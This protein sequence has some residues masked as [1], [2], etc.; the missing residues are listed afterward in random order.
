[1]SH[2]QSIPPNENQARNSTSS[3]RS[4]NSYGLSTIVESELLE[5]DISISEVE[6]EGSRPHSITA[7][8]ENS[9]QTDSNSDRQNSVSENASN[10][11]INYSRPLPQSQARNSI[12]SERS[13]DSFGLSIIPESEKSQDETNTH[14][15]SSH[16]IETPSENSTQ[17]D[18]NSDRQNSASE[19]TSTP[20]INSS[21]PSTSSKRSVSFY[22]PTFPPRESRRPPS[23]DETSAEEKH[24]R[25]ISEVDPFDQIHVPPFTPPVRPSSAY[26]R[27]KSLNSVPLHKSRRHLTREG[28]PRRPS[29][30][31]RAMSAVVPENPIPKEYRS[32][33]VSS[34]GFFTSSLAS[35]TTTLP[36]FQDDIQSQKEIIQEYLA[37]VESLQASKN[38]KPW[39]SNRFRLVYFFLII[40]LVYFILVGQPLWEGI[41][42]IVYRF[43][44]S[45]GVGSWGCALF[46]GWGAFQAFVPML[47]T[48]FEQEVDDVESRDSSQVALVIPAYKAAAVLPET[49]KAALKI[50]KPEQIFIIANGNSKEPTDNTADVC[51]EYGVNHAWVPVGSKLVAEFIGVA[52][53]SKYK[54]TML[55]DDDV[56]LPPNIPIVTDRLQGST[57]C[58]GYTI[59]STG[60]DGIKGTFIQQCQDMEYKLS[61]LTRTFCG[62]YGSATFPHGAIILWET[63]ILRDLFNIHPGYVISEDWYFGHAARSCGYRIQFCS[64]VFVETETPPALFKATSAARGGFGEMTV[65]KQRFGRW[66]YF[67]LMRIWE[68]TVYILLSW[69]LGRREIVTKM[70]VM[71]EVYDSVMA[72]LRPWM[73]VIVALA[74]WR[75]LLIMTAG[76]MLMY[77]GAFCMFNCWHLRKKNEMISFKILPVYMGM[78]FLLLWV[79]SMSVYYGIWD[80]ARYFSVKH[81]K[82]I[83][84]SKVLE[85]AYKIKLGAELAP[86]DITSP[87][88]AREAD[89]GPQVITATAAPL[90]SRALFKDDLHRT[91]LEMQ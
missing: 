60:A 83:E 76:T 19:N 8:S 4:I 7:P 45:K 61:G 71:V 3:E 53:A 81:P 9:I 14:N 20:T 87:E 42:L 28:L 38:R 58:I 33:S 62:K 41:A 6:S 66:N 57:K 10:E 77:I 88:A 47:G 90:M 44:R 75:L 34:L 79:N 5:D 89:F 26:L 69:R 31:T 43:I 51:A 64:Q 24:L 30:M 50:F 12:S 36:I 82:V 49:I 29:L 15:S 40:T 13:I 35:S 74:A 72:L 25:R 56:H 22:T 21:R 2:G 54:Y 55:I 85:I 65:Y 59:K 18:S 46:L 84:N 32:K 86:L 37:G 73:I 52:L 63:K 17:T 48:R 91:D 68:D 78:K 27:S 16:S 80:Y 70:W 11:S 39:E 1:M 23:I 67:F